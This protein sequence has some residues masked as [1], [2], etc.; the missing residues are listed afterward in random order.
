MRY[1]SETVLHATFTGTTANSR[2][3]QGE[4]WA[5]ATDL[6]I[7][8]FNPGTSQ[9]VLVDGHMHR[10]ETKPTI[11][12]PSTATVGNRDK[13]TARGVTYEVDGDPADFHNPYD[14][15]MDGISINLRVVSG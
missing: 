9:E 11:Y 6:G 14:S 15:A 12:L 13:I 3:N 7:Y 5:T 4:S 8:A 2:G 1:I 10:V